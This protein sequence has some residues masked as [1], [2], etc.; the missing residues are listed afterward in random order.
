MLGAEGARPL[1]ALSSAEPDDPNRPG[2]IDTSGVPV[3]PQDVLD[4][5]AQYQNMR[6]ADFAGWSPDGN[7]ILIQTR[8]GNS[9]QVHRVYTPGGRREQITFLDEPV[10][11]R[12]IPKAADGGILLSMSKG[13]NENNQV[14]YLDRAAYRTVL[15]TDG[16][17]RNLLGPV[18]QSG[19]RM[20]VH[21]NLRNGRDTD[22]Y[23]ADTRKPDTVQ[24]LQQADGE[25]WTATDWSADGGRLLLNRY[26]SI[27]ESYPALFHIADKRREALP[28]P[29]EGKVAFGTLVF[30]KDGRSAYVTTDAKSEFLQLARLDL[31]SL[32]YDWLVEDIPWDVTDVEVDDTTGAAAF[33]VNEDGASR[34][35]LL[36]DKKPRELKLPLG[37]V[38]SLEFSPDGKH[39]GFS[40]ARPDAPA[41][42]YSVRIA[43]GEL[44]RW[45][46]SE[47]GGLNPANFIIPE[48][49]QF[50]SFD[51]RQIPAYYYRP[52][53]ASS[54]APAAVLVQIHGG[55]ESQYR[56]LFSGVTQ[57][58]VGEMGIAVICPNVRGSAGYGKT[59]LKLDNAE[60]REDS[61]KDV[62]AL[63]DWVKTRPELDS[64]R[65]AVTGG[66]YGGYMV[67][68]S[69]VNFPER[70]KA[71][72]DIVGIGNFI[73][74]MERTSPYRQDL[75]RAEYGDE[76][77]PEMKAFFEK[78]NPAGRVDKIRSALLV[79]HGLNDPRVPF[80]EAQQM[81]EKVRAAGRPVWTVYADN[82][83]HGFAKKDNRDYLTA[84]EVLFLKENLK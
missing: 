81:A 24:L 2:A 18:E 5:L 34:L 66:S 55:P 73:T 43:D 36:D 47:V 70:I 77:K 49:V 32:K 56:P 25:Y 27:N 54:D 48:P 28:V 68:A 62:G 17:S 12:F 14:Y 38:G 52:R 61:V 3:V 21:S 82:E 29:G 26:V 45:T 20:I 80:F 7:G 78:I 23:V 8:F 22:L 40:L 33:T 6:S 9:V 79:A 11:G 57:Y 51:G 58:M 76:R 75:R 31:T 15:L 1:A 65:V 50:S 35:L 39:L 63:L 13:G 37:I 83:G 4:R 41:D 42:A 19:A 67:L 84:V 72:I 60:L 46:Y 59:Y 10:S 69:L 53:T 71:G 44:T 64:A 16:K 30:S 74:F